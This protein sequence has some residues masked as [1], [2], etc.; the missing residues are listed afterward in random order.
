VVRLVDT[1]IARMRAWLD[2]PSDPET[3][4]EEDV[5]QRLMGSLATLEALRVRLQNPDGPSGASG[6]V[7]ADL[8]AVRKVC[9]MVELMLGATVGGG[10]CGGGGKGGRVSPRL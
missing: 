5:E 10:G 3:D 4:G 2:A 7:S 6:A 9:E 1:Q 8:V